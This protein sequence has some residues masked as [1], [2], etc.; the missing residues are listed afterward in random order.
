MR[1]IFVGV[2]LLMN[3]VPVAAQ[4]SAELDR[5]V[6]FYQLKPDIV[7]NFTRHGDHLF[8]QGS[9]QPAIQLSPDGPNKFMSSHGR[10]RFG[11]DA[12]RNV[13]DVVL[14]EPG[15][16]SKAPRIGAAQARAII[17][18]QEALVK[19]NKPSA[20]AEDA[21]RLQISAFQKGAPDYDAMAPSLASV[22]QKNAE[23]AIALIRKQGGLKS[24]K[25]RNV[26]PGGGNVYDIKFEH[27]DME[28]IIAPLTADGK[29]DHLAFKPL[30]AR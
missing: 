14:T 5:F 24:L 11:Q 10:W 19:A 26:L 27:G 25:F 6:G 18:A 28:W 21:L 15:N 9:G 1:P 2:A 30:T 12:R 22:V 23:M 7:L 13:I 20:G 8:A 17:A 4:R 3:V 29:I 16:E